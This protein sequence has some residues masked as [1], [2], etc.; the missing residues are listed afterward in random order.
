MESCANWPNGWGGA[1][2]LDATATFTNIAAESGQ[3]WSTLMFEVQVEL[4]GAFGLNFGIRR[5]FL[6]VWN[7]FFSVEVSK[8][9]RFEMLFLPANSQTHFY[10]FG[11]YTTGTNRNDISTDT[12]NLFMNKTIDKMSDKHWHHC[13]QNCWQHVWQNRWQ[14]IRQISKTL[15][16]LIHW[17]TQQCENRQSTF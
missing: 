10:F 6:G 17:Q 2:K 14:N 4:R 1:E 11:W 5:S 12:T 3:C 9:F 13:L 15:Q 8:S 7:F 16:K